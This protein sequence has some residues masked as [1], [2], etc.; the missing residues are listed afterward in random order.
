MLEYRRYLR[1]PTVEEIEAVES[2]QSKGRAAPPLEKAIPEGAPLVPLVSVEKL[3]LGKVSLAEAIRERESRRD[4]SDEAL[5][6]EELSFLLWATQGVKKV[7]PEGRW[8]KRTVPS[9]GCRHPFETYLAVANVGSVRPGLYRYSA[10]RHALVGLG[11]PAEPAGRSLGEL[12]FGQSF[13]DEAAVLFVWT[14]VPYR[15]E[16]RYAA[17]S[18]KDILISCGHI[19][20]NLYLACEAIV[21]GT[22][23]ILAY[24]QAAMDEFLGVDGKEEMALYCA[25]VGKRKPE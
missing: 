1:N 11:R 21:A 14:A 17:D 5:S 2:D 23:G 8:A 19:C 20:Q 16:W 25:P 24:D 18:L 6:L 15:T 3:S 7:H 4:Y 22:C 12:C 10:L 13:V 9:G